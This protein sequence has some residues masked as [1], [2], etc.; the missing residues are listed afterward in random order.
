MTVPSFRV[1]H[2]CRSV[3]DVLGGGVTGRDGLYQVLVIAK[4]YALQSVKCRMTGV[5][6][7]FLFS[8]LGWCPM[9]LERLG[10]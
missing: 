2:E 6:G 10:S 5:T 9:Q 1:G 8:P 3:A 4:P 7:F